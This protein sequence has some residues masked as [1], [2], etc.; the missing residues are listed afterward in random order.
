MS[1]KRK[2]RRRGAHDDWDADPQ[3]Q[4][5]LRRAARELPDKIISSAVTVS[6]VPEDN[7]PDPK[8]AVELGYM[9]MLDKP[10]IAIVRP[11]ATPP[12]HLVRVA[13]EIVEWH[14][15]GTVM[16]VRLTNAMERLK[17]NDQD[18]TP[19]SSGP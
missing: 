10:I 5:F 6:I 14:D 19:P 1:N 11:G 8:F 13:D 2:R 16:M 9:I 3:A 12:E 18:D 15:D 4:A 17:V 7:R